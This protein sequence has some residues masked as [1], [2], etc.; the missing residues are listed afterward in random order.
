MRIK[1]IVFLIY[2]AVFSLLFSGISYAATITGEVYDYRLNKLDNVIVFVNSEP[3]QRY[4]LK[5]HTYLFELPPGTYKLTARTFDDEE[6]IFGADEQIVVREEGLF[7]FDLILEPVEPGDTFIISG[8]EPQKGTDYHKIL[9]YTDFFG[10]IVLVLFSLFLLWQYVIKKRIIKRNNEKSKS[11]LGSGTAGK[12]EQSSSDMPQVNYSESGVLV[13][14]VSN[15]GFSDIAVSSQADFSLSDE[16]HFHKTGNDNKN[17][18]N[19]D[20]KDYDDDNKKEQGNIFSD[21]TA[22]KMFLIIKKEK[23]I[24]QKDIRKQMPDSEAKVSLVLAEF[25]SKGIIKKIKK[26]RG[27]IIIFIRK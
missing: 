11:I 22:K 18:S 13:S 4:I 3:V 16:T 7:V 23:R 9:R 14:D 2:F 17:D 6:V 20:D 1:S 25:E 27:N 19:D 12:N 5:N 10:L 26:G 15:D 21:E 8:S 24:T